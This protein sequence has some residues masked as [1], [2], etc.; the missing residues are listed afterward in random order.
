MLHREKRIRSAQESTDEDV[1]TIIAE[2][3]AHAKAGLRD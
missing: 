1:E 3:D 2:R